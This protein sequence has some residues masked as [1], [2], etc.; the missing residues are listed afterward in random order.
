[1]ATLDLVKT[2]LIDRISTSTNMDLLE[3]IDKIFASTQKE[4]IVSLSPG[5]IEML[6]MSE[7]DI[8][9][10]NLISETELEKLDKQWLG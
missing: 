3:A 8:D 6:K 5:Q 1:M 10:G 9:N 2:L 7:Q 4:E